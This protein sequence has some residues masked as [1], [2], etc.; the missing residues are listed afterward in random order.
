MRTAKKV[1]INQMNLLAQSQRYQH[2]FHY[3]EP[4]I[5]VEC[6]CIHIRDRAMVSSILQTVCEIQ[7]NATHMYAMEYAIYSMS[8]YSYEVHKYHL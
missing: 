3:S 6:I 7:Y 5:L 8:M 4:K 2:Y 1:N